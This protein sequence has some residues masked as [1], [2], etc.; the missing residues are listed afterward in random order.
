[1]NCIDRIVKDLRTRCAVTS[2]ETLTVSRFDLQDLCRAYV[3]LSLEDPDERL[4][5]M[6][7]A[8]LAEPTL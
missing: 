6:C 4:C 1:M 3:D 7:K 8:E 2:A 5:D